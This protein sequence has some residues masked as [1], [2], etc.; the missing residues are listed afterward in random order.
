MTGNLRA[1]DPLYVD[2]RHNK[3]AINCAQGKTYVIDMQ[4]AGKNP[5]RDPYL[6]LLDPG[7]NEVARDDDG[8]GGLNA[9]ITYRA[10]QTGQFQ[11]V[12]T[13]CFGNDFGTY[14]L[15]VVEQN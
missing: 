14:T 8:G 10:Q 4:K 2:K 13:N 9:R 15:K 5:M 11:I 7:G 6:I 3:H 12:A 1:T